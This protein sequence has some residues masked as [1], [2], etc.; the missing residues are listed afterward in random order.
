VCGCDGMS[1][2]SD[3]VRQ[4]KGVAKDHDGPCK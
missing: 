3:C 1:Y 4:G 2:A